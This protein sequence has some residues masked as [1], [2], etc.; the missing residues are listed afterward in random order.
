MT[1]YRT[2]QDW[3]QI[4]TENYN[5][6]ITEHTG[7]DMDNLTYSYQIELVSRE[8]YLER[9]ANSVMICSPELLT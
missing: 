7:W 9:L 2:S 4:L 5:I 3:E 8:Q 6:T 1:D